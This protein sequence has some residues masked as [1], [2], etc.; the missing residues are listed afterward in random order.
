[1]SDKPHLDT[2]RLKIAR[3]RLKIARAQRNMLAQNILDAAAKAGLAQKGDKPKLGELIQLARTLG[4]KAK[5]TTERQDAVDR[6]AVPGKRF[7]PD[8][9]AMEAIKRLDKTYYRRWSEDAQSG[10]ER[11]M[12]YTSGNIPAGDLALIVEYTRSQLIEHGGMKP[13]QSPETTV[14][15]PEYNPEMG[16]AALA[17][18]ASFGPEYAKVPEGFLF[19]DLWFGKPCRPKQAHRRQALGQASR[20]TK[21]IRTPNGIKTP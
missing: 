3:S 13:A 8:W 12:G 18:L 2:L 14:D 15:K 6:L 4:E 11:N 9:E 1:M 19:E 20:P 16:K 17:Y 5:A 21:Q 7:I 10:N